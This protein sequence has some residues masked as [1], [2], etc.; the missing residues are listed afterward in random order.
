MGGVKKKMPIIKS[1][2][3]FFDHVCPISGVIMAIIMCG[4]S[5]PQVLRA[6][7][8]NNG[9]GLNLLIYPT[10]IANCAGWIAYSLVTDDCYVYFANVPGFILGVFYF[11]TAY[12]LVDNHQFYCIVLL[13]VFLTWEGL[14]ALLTMFVTNNSARLMWGLSN[15]VILSIYYAS[16]LSV[17]WEVLQS[18]NGTLINPYLA[19]GNLMNGL[20]W[21]LYGLSFNGSRRFSIVVPNAIGYIL[22]MIQIGLFVFYRKKSKRE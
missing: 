7:R 22:S 5:M 10:M 1:K 19:C 18:Q 20:F 15:N 11:G 12:P 2:S 17:I 3:L 13:L 9:E 4:T 8:Q 6:R 21:S 14:L 16:P